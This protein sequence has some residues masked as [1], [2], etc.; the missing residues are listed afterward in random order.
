MKTLL[1]S[2][3]IKVFLWILVALSCPL[4]IAW[5]II[6]HNEIKESREKSWS[7]YV[8]N[9]ERARE[10]FMSKY[11]TIIEVIRERNRHELELRLKYN[12]RAAKMIEEMHSN[13]F[14]V[15]NS[16]KEDIPPYPASIFIED[17]R[18]DISK[19]KRK[20]EFE[21]KFEMS[22]F[23]ESPCNLIEG[24]A[25]QFNEEYRLRKKR[26][27]KRL[28]RSE[29]KALFEVGLMDIKE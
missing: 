15:I 3:R 17:L 29:Q 2:K 26:D 22:P 20:L 7:E 13:S 27:H 11:T 4:I 14:S 6:L 12:L 28:Q 8:K 24:G 21:S 18:E 1:A 9:D 10:E 23:R 25:I 5:G 19:I 16:P